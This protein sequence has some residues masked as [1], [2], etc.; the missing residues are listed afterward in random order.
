MDCDF[1]ADGFR[2]PTNDEWGY[3]EEGGENYT[4]A[5]SDDLDE[6]GWYDGNSGTTHPVGEKKPNGYGLYDMN[7]NVQ[8]WTGASVS[9]SVLRGGS[10]NLSASNC[11][12]FSWNDVYPSSRQALYGFRVVRSSSKK[13][14]TDF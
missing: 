13:N 1:S 6:V 12:V 7:G 5:G 3:A 8:E 4:Y 11:A 10:W 14:P 9:D 2:L